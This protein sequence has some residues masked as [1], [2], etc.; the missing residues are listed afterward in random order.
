MQS[1][2]FE[3]LRV[4]VLQ[5]A[6]LQIELQNI[7]DR[8]EFISRVVQIAEEFGLDLNS[9]GIVNA[10]QENRRTWIERWI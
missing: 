4:I 8:D 3:K 1:E 10:I 7:S 9:E 6:E 5:N 2:E